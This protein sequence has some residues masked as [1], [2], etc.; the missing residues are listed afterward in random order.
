[1]ETH[2]L[3][4]KMIA[5][6]PKIARNCESSVSQLD[7]A[8]IFR[9]DHFPAKNSDIEVLRSFLIPDGEEVRGEEAFV[10]NGRFG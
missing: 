3:A 7:V 2:G 4:A 5:K 10:C 1:M 8:R 6:M 9:L